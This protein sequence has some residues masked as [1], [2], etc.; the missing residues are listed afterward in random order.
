MNL[1]ELQLSLG[2]K[3]REITTELVQTLVRL[4]NGTLDDNFK[5]KNSVSGFFINWN[6]FRWKT[7]WNRLQSG[8]WCPYNKNHIEE[9]TVREFIERKGGKVQSTWAYKGAFIK[10]LIQCAEGHSWEICWSNLLKGHWCP[11]CAYKNNAKKR[12]KSKEEIEEFIRN[13][14]GRLNN[15]WY[16]NYKNNLSKIEIFC[17]KGHS[18][19][20]VWGNISQGQWCPYCRNNYIQQE[21]FRQII[22]KTIGFPFPSK[23]PEFLKNILSGRNLELDGYNEKLKIAFEY[24]GYQHYEIDKA[25]VF[26][27]GLEAAQEKLEEIQQRDLFKITKCIEQDVLL[28]VVPY[29]IPERDWKSFIEDKIITRRINACQ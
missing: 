22:E 12:K 17:K 1:P 10:F 20:A 6:G 24:Q 19:L 18:W 14:K 8:K 15:N 28:I 29:W 25:V 26:R 3:N 21:K 16:Q 9:K 11:Y 27:R 5:W 13:K 23:K 4:K 2:L 7:T